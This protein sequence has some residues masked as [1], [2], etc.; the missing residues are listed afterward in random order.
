MQDIDWTRPTA[1]VLGNEL[2][3]VSP[4]AL[5]AADA[6][7]VIPMAGFVESFNI[8]VAAAL[9]MYEAAQQR[10]RKLGGCG[11]DLSAAQQQQ[12]LASFLMRGVVSVF[13]FLSAGVRQLGFAKAG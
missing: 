3:G 8:S 12:L 10:A 9:V 1:F 2:R 6:T 13:G 11:G 4:D 7:A 5:A